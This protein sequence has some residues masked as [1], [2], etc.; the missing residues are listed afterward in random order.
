[1]S[2]A[3][4]RPPSVARRTVTLL[5]ERIGEDRRALAGRRLAAGQ[6]CAVVAR[7]TP[8][9]PTVHELIAPACP[10]APPSRRRLRPLRSYAGANGRGSRGVCDVY[11]LVH[12]R[13]YEVFALRS[14]TQ[15]DHYVAT[16]RGGAL[17]RVTQEEVRTWAW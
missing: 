17:V 5:L 10:G 2:A 16:V 4:R 9:P 12:G 14:W 3:P 7:R 6:S 8:P 15:R 1:M 11:H 13:L